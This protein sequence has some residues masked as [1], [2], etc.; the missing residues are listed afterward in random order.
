MSWCLYSCTLTFY[1]EEGVYIFW[2]SG[3]LVLLD[4]FV[5]C[6][7]MAFEL[8]MADAEKR[9]DCRQ[10]A[11]DEQSEIAITRISHDH[12]A[13]RPPPYTPSVYAGT[14]TR[15]ASTIPRESLHP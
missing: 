8:E 4:T 13:I 2:T 7:D 3:Y 15:P 11:V 9:L 14:G 12:G 10:R 6:A 1:L 5:G